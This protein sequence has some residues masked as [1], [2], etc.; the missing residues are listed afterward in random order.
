MEVKLHAFQI[1][2]LM[3][4]TGQLH[5]LAYVGKPPQYPFHV[6]VSCKDSTQCR[7]RETTT[8]HNY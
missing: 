7:E 2:A 5:A 1:F 6:L 3:D 4:M 8:I